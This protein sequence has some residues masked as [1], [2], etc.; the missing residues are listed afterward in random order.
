MRAMG[1]RILVVDDEP[2]FAG[3][4][5]QGLSREGYSVDIA[6]TGKDGRDRALLG[7]YDLAILDWMLPQVTGLEICKAMRQS[8]KTTPIL[9]VTAKD[10]TDDRVEG[11]DAGADDYII[12]PFELRELLARVRA[13]LRR[14]E[15]LSLAEVPVPNRLRVGSRE[16]DADD[17]ILYQ[18]GTAIVLSEKETKLLAL[19]MA[20][21]H[22]SISHQQ[23]Y[24]EVWGE[25]ETP[26]SNV[27]AALV[28]LLR[29]KIDRPDLPDFIQTIYGKGYRVDG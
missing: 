13:L 29:R 4:M 5:F 9:F 7:D 27:L 10:T 2:A 23:I 21:P 14:A 15:V 26:N 22:Q 6:A 18:A 3:A 12:K 20:Q 11:L 25:G 1:A 17:R 24:R 8:G 19:L 28:R 16:L